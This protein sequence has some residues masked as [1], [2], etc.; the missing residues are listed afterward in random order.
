MQRMYHHTAKP[1]SLTAKAY[2]GRLSD[3]ISAT[4][5]DTNLETTRQSEKKLRFQRE[6]ANLEA[7]FM[8]V[9]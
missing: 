5:G 9:A 7:R 6:T 1:A 8:R 4:I 2:D 3:F